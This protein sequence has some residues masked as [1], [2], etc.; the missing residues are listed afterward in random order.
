MKIGNLEVN[1][2]GKVINIPIYHA[3][4]TYGC[5]CVNCKLAKGEI[6]LDF[7]KGFHLGVCLQEGKE[8]DLVK[9]LF[10]EDELAEYSMN[11]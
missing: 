8:D 7:Y 6:S 4:G 11:F 5:A 10:N 2:N 3:P 1:D 9:L